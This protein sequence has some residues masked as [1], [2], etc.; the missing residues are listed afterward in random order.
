MAIEQFLYFD[1]VAYGRFAGVHYF[2][3]NIFGGN[4]HRSDFC[5]T[6]IMNQLNA[7]VSGMDFMA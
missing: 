2:F 3:C 4:F 5:K 6:S 1:P 7:R